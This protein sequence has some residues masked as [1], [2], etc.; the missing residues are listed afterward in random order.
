MGI[1]IIDCMIITKALDI[2]QIYAYI[3][4]YNMTWHDISD[5]C[6]EKKQKHM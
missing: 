1:D 5:R 2:N 6:Q 4:I 3:Y